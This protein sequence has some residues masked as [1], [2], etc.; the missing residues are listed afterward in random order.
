MPHPIVIIGDGYAAA[1]LLVHLARRHID[2][3]T[4]TVIG[5]APLGHG[6]AYGTDKSAFPV[7]CS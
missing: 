3:N 6:A 7:K 1:V 5:D 2:M 4:V